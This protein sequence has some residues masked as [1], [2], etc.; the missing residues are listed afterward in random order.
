ML[1]G[2]YVEATNLPFYLRGDVLDLP[3]RTPFFEC[4]HDPCGHSIHQ[5]RI[6]HSGP[7]SP[8]QHPNR[9]VIDQG[10]AT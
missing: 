9:H 6:N 8:V 2:R 7:G 3:R 10:F 4:P 5:N 1:P